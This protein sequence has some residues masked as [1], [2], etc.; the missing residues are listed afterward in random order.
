MLSN[1]ANAPPNA[2]FSGESLRPGALSG[3]AASNSE[4]ENETESRIDEVGEIEVARHAFGAASGEKA[5][6]CWCQTKPFDPASAARRE[7]KLEM[8]SLV[9]CKAHRHRLSPK[10]FRV[11]FIEVFIEWRQESIARFL[12]HKGRVAAHTKPGFDTG[13]HK[14]RPDSS[15]MIAA[16][17]LDSIARFIWPKATSPLG[18]NS[19][20]STTSTT[21]RAGSSSRRQRDKPPTAKIWV[22]TQAGVQNAVLVVTVDYTKRQRRTSFQNLDRKDCRPESNKAC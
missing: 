20:A 11:P 10:R 3:S 16:V 13:A 19:E 21:A 7:T 22:W 5:V 2:S 4:H 8:D 9:G 6:T 15:L 17:A 18:V 12:L 1:S 14:P